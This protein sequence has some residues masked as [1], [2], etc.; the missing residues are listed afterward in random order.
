MREHEPID[1]DEMR[2]KKTQTHTELRS[3]RMTKAKTRSPNRKTH[4]H[5]HLNI[6]K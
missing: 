4:A 1:R 5:D 3:H 2:W 6:F